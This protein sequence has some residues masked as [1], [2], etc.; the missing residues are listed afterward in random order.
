LLKNK[1][2]PILAQLSETA[3]TALE[4]QQQWTVADFM[5]FA[6]WTVLCIGGGFLIDAA[7]RQISRKSKP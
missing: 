2:V 4:R 6:V 3:K 7:F 1:A 5:E